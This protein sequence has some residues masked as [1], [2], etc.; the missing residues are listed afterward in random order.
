MQPKW[1]RKKIKMKKGNDLRIFVA[2]KIKS[3]S[4]ATRLWDDGGGGC[5]LYD[6][7]HL[8]TIQDGLAPTP[9]PPSQPT[10]PS[11]PHSQK[12]V[13][14]FN[15]RIH[16]TQLSPQALPCLLT[17]QPVQSINGRLMQSHVLVKLPQAL[18]RFYSSAADAFTFKNSSMPWGSSISPD[19]LQSTR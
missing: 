10:S 7:W 13:F 5:P 6:C 17:E 19:H 14:Y 15:E 1:R 4:K 11:H 16:D 9:P 12:L 8:S 3:T 18:L 2:C